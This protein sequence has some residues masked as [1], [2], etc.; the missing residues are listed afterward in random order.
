MFL[1]LQIKTGIIMFKHQRRGETTYGRSMLRP[2]AGLPLWKDGYLR[3]ELTHN[4]P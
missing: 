4:R 3:T 1:V 2:Y